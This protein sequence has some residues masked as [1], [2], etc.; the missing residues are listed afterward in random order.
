MSAG[1]EHVG[2]SG[3]HGSLLI[4]RLLKNPEIRE[5]L[6]KQRTV[7]QEYDLPYLGGYSKGG[8]TIYID[9][10]LPDVLFYD[11]DGQKREFNPL[12][13]IKDH[14]VFEKTVM[15]VLHWGYSASHEAATG[16]ERRNV[17][18]AGLFWKPYNSVVERYVKADEHEKL[19][20]VPADLDM[21]PYY[22]KPVDHSLIARMEKVMGTKNSAKKSKS[23]V[24]YSDQGHE[25]SHCGPTKAWPHGYCS[26]FEAPSG[27]ELVRGE[28]NK[29]GWCKLWHGAE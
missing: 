23:E 27:C 14:E 13:F 11:A 9:R 21:A 29:R 17:L 5:G 18:K 8:D 1:H 28:I 15:D 25:T 7:N 12:E 26:H 3:G 20:K 24:D 16:Y 19:K 6:Y 2:V 10:H 22:A 4:D